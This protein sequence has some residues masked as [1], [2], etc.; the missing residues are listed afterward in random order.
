MAADPIKNKA[1]NADDQL[2]WRDVREAVLQVSA[3]AQLDLEIE[4]GTRHAHI[5]VRTDN[6]QVPP[7]TFVAIHM[8]DIEPKSPT[9][10]VPS[11]K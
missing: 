8:W 4:R 6:K 2:F 5:N 1:Q 9:L 10:I 3:N 7:R 11:G